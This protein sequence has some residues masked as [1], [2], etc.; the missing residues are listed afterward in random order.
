MLMLTGVAWGTSAACTETDADEVV[1]DCSVC[2]PKTLFVASITLA[3][4]ETSSA[5][6]VE[7]ACCSRELAWITLAL[8]IM[9]DSFETR[10]LITGL[11]LPYEE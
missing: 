11:T 3:M 5:E 7:R 6:A 1:A 10:S 9:D 8:S 2:G 4:S